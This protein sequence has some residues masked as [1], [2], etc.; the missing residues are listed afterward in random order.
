MAISPR[1]LSVLGAG[2]TLVVIALVFS[3]V[4]L[5]YNIRN[6]TIRWK[7]TVLTGLAFTLVV[8]LLTVMLAF[9]NGMTALTESGHPENVIVLSDGATDESWSTLLKTDLSDV[10]RVKGVLTDEEKRPL[11]SQEVYIIASQ[12]KKPGP[13]QPERRR[14]VQVRGID[15]PAIAAKVHGIELLPGGT[16]FSEA[17]VE[18]LPTTDGIE[19]ETAV[20]TVIGEGVARELGKDL[21]KERLQP[22]DVFELGPKKWK[23]TGIMKSSGSTFGSEVWA[24]RSYVSLLYG[25]E[26]ISTIALRT[27]G[28]DKA[29]E[30]AMEL[31]N[32]F[33][34]A[35][36]QA[37]TETEYYSK[38]TATN[39]QFLFGAILVTVIMAFGGI[40]G[41]MNTMFAAISQ[42]I[43]DIGVLRI[44]GFTRRQVLVSFFLETMVIALIGGI[45]GCALGSL[46]H[47][48][49]A[50]SIISGGQG[51]FG[52]TV[53]LR[54]AVN[55]NTLAA[56]MMLTLFMG[57]VGGL[58]PALS[59]M[60]LRPLESLR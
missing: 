18:A 59:A 6:L 16:W 20:Q 4:P 12:T 24:K 15:D 3:K 14:F 31:T 33:K 19:Q 54:L 43:K 17:G 1:L 49:T 26:T 35:N 5:S 36:L 40:F 27:G 50:T 58:V 38:L 37:Q 9:V 51:G 10:D 13:G 7:T 29:K 53:V 44:L 30:V 46:S 23:V 28:A 45:L 57:V 48:W 60:R 8:A 52:K 41:V 25:K 34:K 55:A 42:R 39:K 56:G 2:F 47:G 11:S 22:G 32:N 21:N